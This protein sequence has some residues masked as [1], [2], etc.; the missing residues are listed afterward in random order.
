[1]IW[2]IRF[3]CF[4]IC[5]GFVWLVYV[6]LRDYLMINR[7]HLSRQNDFYYIWLVKFFKK[8]YIEKRLLCLIEDNSIQKYDQIYK[9]ARQHK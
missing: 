4:I 7:I 6:G 5:L 3:K 8:N 2:K 1:M 9:Y